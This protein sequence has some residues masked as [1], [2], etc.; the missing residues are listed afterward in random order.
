MA[1]RALLCGCN[2]PGTNAELR[3]CINDCMAM[4]AL[5]TEHFGFQ[6]RTKLQGMQHGLRCQ[7]SRK[8]RCCCSMPTWAAWGVAAQLA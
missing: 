4:R 7:R 8:P 3:G 5:L 6:V 1:R 2:Y